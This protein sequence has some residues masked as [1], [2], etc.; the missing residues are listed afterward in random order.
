M[1]LIIQMWTFTPG[2]TPQYDWGLDDP[3]IYLRRSR[4]A[5]EAVPVAD[6]RENDMMVEMQKSIPSVKGFN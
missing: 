5:V 3:S 2:T 4:G 1:P 6:M